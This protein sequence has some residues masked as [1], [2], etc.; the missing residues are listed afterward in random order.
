MIR[1]CG[2]LVRPGTGL[3]AVTLLCLL[4]A[5]GKADNVVF[6]NECRVSVV[7]QTSTVIKGQVIRDQPRLL[8]PGDYTPRISLNVDRIV[9]VYDARTNKM[10]F[11]DV[12]RASKK[13][14]AFAIQPDPN[15][16][17][18]ARMVPRAPSTMK[19]AE[20]DEGH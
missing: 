12:L 13:P 19:P 9:T 17:S 5:L 3:L 18:K 8:R 7:V 20:A 11:R 16:M 10:I 2:G 14:S 6:R 1:G 4:P 15:V